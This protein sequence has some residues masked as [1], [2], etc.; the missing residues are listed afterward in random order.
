MEALRRSKASAGDPENLPPQRWSLPCPL[1]ARSLAERRAH[2]TKE[3]RPRCSAGAGDRA[4]VPL[5]S[6]YGGLEGAQT[7]GRIAGAA[8]NHFAAKA[9]DEG[10][11]VEVEDLDRKSTRLNSSH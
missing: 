4:P 11:I 2:R 1:T 6:P 3:D 8:P 7:Q 10:T 9:L 5:V